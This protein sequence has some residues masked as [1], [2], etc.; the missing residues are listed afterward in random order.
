M[1][2][3]NGIL[4]F[5]SPFVEEFD[6]AKKKNKQKLI[7][8]RQKWHESKNLPRKK[9]K[10]IRKHLMLDYSIFKW[11]EDNL[12]PDFGFDLS[13]LFGATISKKEHE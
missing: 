4:G 12:Y 10:L 6:E 9:K 2:V 11:A 5:V 3:L 8:I 1:D 7:E 13:D